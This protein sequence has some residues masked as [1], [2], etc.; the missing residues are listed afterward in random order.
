M[1]NKTKKDKILK[2][3]NTRQHEADTLWNKLVGLGL[4][5]DDLTPLRNAMDDFVSN[6]VG[7]SGHV[8][9]PSVTTHIIE[10]K[11]SVSP[12][13]VSEIKLRHTHPKS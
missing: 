12:H 7:S 9:L 11:F 4:P 1:K 13:C 2:C 6:G 5:T 8:K 3:A 10:Y